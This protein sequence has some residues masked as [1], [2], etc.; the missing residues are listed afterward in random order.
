[1]TEATRRDNRRDNRTG[2]ALRGA[3][4]AATATAVLLGGF[5]AFAL[6]NDRMPAGLDDDIAT[7]R[8]F[9]D[10][11]APASDDGWFFGDGG[12]GVV[13]ANDPVDLKTFKASPGDRVY[14]LGTVNVVAEGSDMRAKLTVDPTS[15]LTDPEL[16]DHVDAVVTIDGAADATIVGSESD[17]PTSHSVKVTVTFRDTLGAA[18]GPDAGTDAGDDGQGIVDA[19]QLQDLAFELTQIH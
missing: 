8:L 11:V 3:I 5:G 9:I 1:M 15:I 12:D 19:V 6:W 13:K 14:W 2:L 17:E 18:D 16:E 4:A 10:S 7:G